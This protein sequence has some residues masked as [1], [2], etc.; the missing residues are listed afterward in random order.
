MPK[1][2][3]MSGLRK[4]L[5]NAHFEVARG[6]PDQNYEYCTKD[7][8]DAVEFGDREAGGQGKRSDI[9]VLRDALK[10]KAS[11][12]ELLEDDLTA[13]QFFKYQH[14]LT[15]ARTAYDL[16]VQR[17]GIKVALF[18][19]APGTGKSHFARELFPNAYWKDNTKWWP[20]YTGQE[21]V[22][23]DEFGGWSCTPSEFNKVF[24]QYPHYVEIKGGTVPLKALH[25]IIISNFTPFQWWDADKTRVDLRSITRRIQKFCRFIKIGQEFLEFDDIVKFDENLRGQ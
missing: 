14:G 19:G 12:I 3:R 22:I 9:L 25:F 4:V 10:R 18:F 15:A 2:I 6:S 13:P 16:P 7:D 24:D 11:D 17:D 23:W 21:A 20:G 1:A 5:G 8:P